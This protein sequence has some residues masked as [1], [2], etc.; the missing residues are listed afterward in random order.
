MRRF[1]FTVI[2]LLPMAVAAVDEGDACTPT[3]RLP[4]RYTC[5]WGRVHDCKN[6]GGRN[7]HIA[8]QGRALRQ[9]QQEL[10]TRYKTLLHSFDGE[11]ADGQ[12]FVAA[13]NALTRSQSAWQK[14]ADAECE[15]QAAT[16][17]AGNAAAPVENDCRVNQVKNRIRHLNALGDGGK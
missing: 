12:D 14:L 7:S 6:P 4:P 17:G 15:L 10:Q 5:E 11:P 1:L 16:F 8:C 3:E 13:K 2:F 9:L